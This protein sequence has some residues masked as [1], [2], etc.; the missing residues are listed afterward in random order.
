MYVYKRVPP[1]V[2]YLFAAT[3]EGDNFDELAAE[4]LGDGGNAERSGEA[5]VLRLGGAEYHLPLNMALVVENGIGR[6]LSAEAF[7]EQYESAARLEAWEASVESRLAALAAKVAGEET[8][9]AEKSEGKAAPKRGGSRESGAPV[10]E[11]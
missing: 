7:R 2:A 8:T 4:V 11:G 5:A 3:A 1:L 10:V 6:L 9:G